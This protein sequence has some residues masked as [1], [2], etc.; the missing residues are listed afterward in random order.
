MNTYPFIKR[1]PR[2]HPVDG[3]A[4]DYCA[5]EDKEQQEKD[6]KLC[7][8]L[9]RLAARGKLGPVIAATHVKG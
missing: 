9:M 4:C 1:C 8:A 7:E 2:G 3:P 5:Q 6:D